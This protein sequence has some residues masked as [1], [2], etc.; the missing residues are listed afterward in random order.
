MD[1]PTLSPPALLEKVGAIVN[2]HFI[3]TSGGHAAV[4]VNKD[5]LYP[6]TLITAN[7]CRAIAEAFSRDRVEAVIAPAIGGVILSQ[8]VAFHF[9]QLSGRHAR[10][11][12]FA[13]YAEKAE[14]GSFV[15]GRGYDKFLPGRRVLVVEDV[16]T[17]GGSAKKVVELARA[18]GGKVIGL[19]VLCNRGGVT[20]HDV[21]DVPQL[22]ALT[23]IPLEVWMEGDCPLCKQGVPVNTDIGK[24]R[25][26]LAR[27]RAK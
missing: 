4:Y 22:F 20:P 24:G 11:E 27:P 10:R 1:V 23:N 3:L 16:L 7:L 17:T 18:A 21:G 8:W 12:V 14:G 9:T 15:I 5:A 13:L 19:G 26:F 6:R 25:E 2:G